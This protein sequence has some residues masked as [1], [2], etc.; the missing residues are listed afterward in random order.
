MF[1][2][3]APNILF[4]FLLSTYFVSAQNRKLD[5]LNRIFPKSHDTMKVYILCSISRF[6][7]A[8]DP[9]RAIKMADSALAI[10]KRA[11][12]QMGIGGACGSLGSCLCT[13][14]RY[15][16]SIK[17]LINAIKIFEAKNSK[18]HLANTYNTMAN[19]YMG[20]KNNEKAYEYFLKSYNM[21][22]EDPTNTF[23]VAV[24]GVG[25]GNMLME[26]GKLKEAIEYYKTSE[27]VFRDN[28]VP[29]YEAMC[30]TMIGET[31]VKD[32]NFVEAEKYFSKS[33]PLFKSSNDEYG[34][35]IN[36]ANLGSVEVNRKNYKKAAE[37]Y[38]EAL[39]INLHRKA[40]D[41]IQSTAKGL[42][43]VLELQNK[44][45]EALAAYK[46][47]MQYKDSVVN[48]ERNKAIAEAEGKYE[49]E[50][51]EQQLQLKN[52]ELEKSH[53]KVAQRNH[54][55]YIFAG[56]ILVFLV[57]LFFVYKQ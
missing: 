8:N 22:K 49:N 20:L 43:E 39:K 30:I 51:K 10:A 23:M 44:P 46:I 31:Y 37:Y 12:F 55:I 35:A 2:R 4:V 27:K 25:V 18:R 53:L 28:N 41:N 50:K 36:L 57:L 52:S 13:A 54:L 1:K 56:A 15:D 11:N 17:T 34:Y 19:A 40:M 3:I 21:A 29:N 47:Y 48:T 33:L 26:M 7:E 14:G 42:A 45:T 24:A 5:S 9:E 16:E 38:D 6:Y 32:S